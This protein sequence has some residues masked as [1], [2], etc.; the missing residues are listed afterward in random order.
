MSEQRW[1][2]RRSHPMTTSIEG[3]RLELGESLEVCPTEELALAQRG[4][5]DLDTV[6]HTLLLRHPWPWIVQSD[7]T[8]EV[9]ASDGL[10]VAKCMTREQADRI[11]A[12]ARR[13]RE[14]S[15]E[16]TA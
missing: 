13:I 12:R 6:L 14:G 11:V 3:P 8:E 5:E 9:I 16:A 15:G 4:V 1:T 2:L 10:C 7:W